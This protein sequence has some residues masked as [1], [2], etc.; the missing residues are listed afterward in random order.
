MAFTPG[1]KS[2]ATNLYGP[3]PITSVI[4][5]DTG[6][7]AMRLGMM[8]GTGEAGLA[9]ASISMPNGC[10]RWNTTVLASGLSRL[11][12]TAIRRRP[13]TSRSAQRLSDATTSS[14]V[15]GE[16]S[17]NLRLGRSVSVTV[18]RSGLSCQLCTISGWDLPWAS[19]ANSVSNTM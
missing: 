2:A 13:S 7:E 14:P 12:V 19:K 4:A 6:T 10:F 17:W 15:T 11:R 16:P 9:R 1:W 8:K 18:R 3:E 5:C